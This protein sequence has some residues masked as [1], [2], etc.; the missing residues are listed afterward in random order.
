MA[1][2]GVRPDQPRA[3]GPSYPTAGAAVGGFVAWGRKCRYEGAATFVAAR[4][5]APVGLRAR[6]VHAPAHLRMLGRLVSLPL[7]I[8]FIEFIT[9]EVT[10]S[11]VRAAGAASVQTRSEG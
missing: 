1:G 11:E 6:A 10:L 5:L 9:I 3:A 8:P 4:E 7:G 2:D